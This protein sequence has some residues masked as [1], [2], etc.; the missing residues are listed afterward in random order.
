MINQIARAIQSTPVPGL[1]TAS[2]EVV[3]VQEV[4]DSEVE[5]KGVNWLLENLLNNGFKHPVAAVEALTAIE[6]EFRG[7]G[8]SRRLVHSD[9]G[10][11]IKLNGKDISR[12]E[13]DNF[14]YS[15]KY[16]ELFLELATELETNDS[17]TKRN[18]AEITSFDF[19]LKNLVNKEFKN[20]LAAV[21]AIVTQPQEFHGPYRKL[22]DEN[23]DFV[24]FSNGDAITNFATKDLVFSNDDSKLL[25]EI[26]QEFDELMKF[27]Q[28]AKEEMSGFDF[29]LRNLLEN[30]FKNPREA[31]AALVSDDRKFSQDS[32]VD[33]NGD[34]VLTKRDDKIPRSLVENIKFTTETKEL[35]TKITSILTDNEIPQNAVTVFKDFL[36]SGYQEKDYTKL[37]SQLSD[38]NILP[39]KYRG[40]FASPILNTAAKFQELK[41]QSTIK[42]KICEGIEAGSDTLKADL[43][44]F[45][46]KNPSTRDLKIYGKLGL[47]I[48]QAKKR[49]IIGTSIKGLGKSSATNVLEYLKALETLGMGQSAKNLSTRIRD[50]A[51][52]RE[53]NALREKSMNSLRKDGTAE[54][55]DKLFDESPL[56]Q[57]A[58][59][60]E[61]K[62]LYGLKAKFLSLHKRISDFDEIWQRGGTTANSSTSAEALAGEARVRRQ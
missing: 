5:P 26:A 44:V 60:G 29:A 53:F 56:W 62:A 40:R 36:K 30:D 13:I 55:I 3:E 8:H 15:P 52:Q 10:F 11:S 7:A 59:Q 14:R 17:D 22:L 24:E 51:Y 38:S 6:R 20:P 1:K 23:R 18:Q 9:L 58:S 32:L 34:W 41:K 16:K 37:E 4:Q 42:Q 21:K 47:L 54:Q 28:A 25:I 19:V 45:H 31:V 33:S 43:E 2:S 57:I 61:T 12:A 50:L 35:I 48:E 39:D 27:S 49:N 46:S